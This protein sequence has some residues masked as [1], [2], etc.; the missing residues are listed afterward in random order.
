MAAAKKQT[1]KKPTAKE[2]AAK[3]AAA[4]RGMFMAV[5]QHSDDIDADDM[6]MRGECYDYQCT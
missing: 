2:P 1:A 4:K 3:K 6:A 5:A